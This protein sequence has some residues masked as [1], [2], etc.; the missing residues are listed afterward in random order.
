MKKII[1]PIFAVLFLAGLVFA[2][3]L[4]W[5]GTT[6]ISDG[7]IRINS[8]IGEMYVNSNNTATPIAAQRKWY[9][10]TSLI[11]GDLNGFTSSGGYLTATQAGKYNAEFSLSFA[12]TGGNDYNYRIYKNE[13]KQLKC[14]SKASSTG[15]GDIVNVGS[16]CFIDLAV[17]DYINLRVMNN[18]G[19][20]DA[21]IQYANVKLV[22]EGN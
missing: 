4:R 21:T 10:I 13:D 7:N 3:E 17:D 8:Y 19:T 20:G 16:Q 15:L 5:D 1:I 22:R 14:E 2:S 6:F 18:D 11:A 9:N 12:G